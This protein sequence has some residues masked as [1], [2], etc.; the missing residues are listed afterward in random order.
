MEKPATVISSQ[1]RMPDTIQRDLERRR[2]TSLGRLSLCLCQ[3]QVRRAYLNH[4]V[5]LGI[6]LLIAGN[7]VSNIAEKQNNE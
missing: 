7:F 3:P 6:A 5:Q 1:G 4:K 2:Q